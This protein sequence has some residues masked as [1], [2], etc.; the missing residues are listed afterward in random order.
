MRSYHWQ[1]GNNSFILPSQLVDV[2][3]WLFLAPVPL[4]HI[5][6]LPFHTGKAF[7]RQ[8]SRKRHLGT[9][10]YLWLNCVN[11]LFFGESS[12]CAVNE[13]DK[14]WKR[15]ISVQFYF[16]GVEAHSDTDRN[17]GSQVRV[18]REMESSEESEMGSVEKVMRATAQK[19]LGTVMSLRCS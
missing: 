7:V 15:P 13:A 4:S 9:S 17:E 2:K 12:C 19:V 14:S 18:E 6:R 11:L 1:T 10:Q 16:S 3:L 8:G 5:E